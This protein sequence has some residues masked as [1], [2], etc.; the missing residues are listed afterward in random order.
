[1]MLDSQFSNCTMQIVT[2]EKKIKVGWKKR[3]PPS[4]TEA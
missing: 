1:M 4:S 2:R 3:P